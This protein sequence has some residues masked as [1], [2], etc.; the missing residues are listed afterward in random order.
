MI[1]ECLKILEF[2]LESSL[3]NVSEVIFYMEHVLQ[4]SLSLIKVT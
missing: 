4:A 1:I 3:L 2:F